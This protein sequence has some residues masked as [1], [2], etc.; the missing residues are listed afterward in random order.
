MVQGPV[1]FKDALYHM[2]NETQF[3]IQVLKSVCNTDHLFF[4]LRMWPEQ[5]FTDPFAWRD[6]VWETVRE[7][8]TL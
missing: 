2:F 6:P 8:L 5:T 3:E 7:L 1:E 4:Y